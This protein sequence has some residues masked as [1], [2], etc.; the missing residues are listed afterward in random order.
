MTC[1]VAKNLLSEYIDGAL[2]VGRC[3]ELEGHLGSCESCQTE[4]QEIRTIRRILQE[5]PEEQAPPEFVE[6]LM[7]RVKRR[8]PFEWIRDVFP[9]QLPQRVLVGGASAAVLVVAVLGIQRGSIVSIGELV[10]GPGDPQALSHHEAVTDESLDR[11]GLVGAS[12][13]KARIQ[14]EWGEGGVEHLLSSEVEQEGASVS[15][16]VAK[17]SQRV[18]GKTS[19][20][21]GS[22]G[23]AS[24]AVPSEVTSLSSTKNKKV[25]KGVGSQAKSSAPQKRSA[26]KKPRPMIRPARKSDTKEPVPALEKGVPF[27]ADA[28]GADLQEEVRNGEVWSEATLAP[29]DSG[30]SSVGAASEGD[31]AQNAP[32][33]SRK[34]PVSPVRVDCRLVTFD[35]KAP[36]RVVAAALASGGKELRWPDGPPDFSDDGATVVLEVLLSPHRLSGFERSVA[37][38]GKLSFLDAV[39]KGIDIVVLEI[40]VN[41]KVTP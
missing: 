38:L 11:G 4:L 32:P 5:L 28:F 40:Q 3:R 39:P 37:K 15:K 13:D 26:P 21:A 18:R 27:R 24:P 7:A 9:L 14:N 6:A 8:T 34:A 16:N 36:I 12:R 25:A 33:K 31:F 22:S 41:Y 35:K 17:E 30:A 29:Q 2:A 1:F 20:S 23:G 10:G 19:S